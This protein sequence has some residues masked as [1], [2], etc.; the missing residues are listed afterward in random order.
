MHEGQEKT[1][2]A[3]RTLAACGIEVGTN[4]RALSTSQMGALLAYAEQHRLNKY[5]PSSKY[6]MPLNPD[7][8]SF[9]DLLQRRAMYRLRPSSSI[10]EKAAE[11]SATRPAT[12]RRRRRRRSLSFGD[13]SPMA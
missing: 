8:R 10:S 12:S 2:R 1:T 11:R 4:F 9:Y 13:N 7:L 5:G 6:R 3:R